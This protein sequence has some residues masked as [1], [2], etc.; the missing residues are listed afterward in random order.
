MAV[1]ESTRPATVKDDQKIAPPKAI[2]LS[3]NELNFIKLNSRQTDVKQF[4]RSTILD[5]T[6]ENGP[7]TLVWLLRILHNDESG[8]GPENFFALSLI[9]L[10]QAQESEV[11][12]L[13]PSIFREGDFYPIA[14]P[15][16][17]KSSGGRKHII[18]DTYYCLAYNMITSPEKH[19]IITSHSKLAIFVQSD[20]AGP[21][22]LSLKADCYSRLCMMRHFQTMATDEFVHAQA[23]GSKRN[24]LIFEQNFDPVS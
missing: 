17:F 16:V 15:L 7:E 11:H 3:E 21:L 18:Y 14:V 13:N 22:V 4:P 9:D 2:L 10:S 5:C 8:I 12:L 23:K 24:E 1:S 20:I 6:F 19:I